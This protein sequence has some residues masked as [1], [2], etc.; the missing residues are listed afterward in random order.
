MVKWLKKTITDC[1]NYFG[2]LSKILFETIIR[3]FQK[4]LLK[5]I[6]DNLEYFKKPNCILNNNSKLIV[7]L[8]YD[9]FSKFL[10]DKISVEFPK[11]YLETYIERNF[12]TEC[13]KSCFQ[14]Y[15]NENEEELTIFCINIS[16][17]RFISKPIKNIIN[18]KSHHPKFSI[19]YCI[20]MQFFLIAHIN[21]RT[22]KFFIIKVIFC[23]FYNITI[24]WSIFFRIYF[25]MFEIF[26][27]C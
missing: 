13:I 2:D 7:Q 6:A 25:I 26:I 24:K 15:L 23:I 5:L 16:Q 11:E 18:N 27:K 17:N 14:S 10:F 20:K 12:Y 1:N 3:L 19:H 9:G 8:D 4:N 21:C 22:I